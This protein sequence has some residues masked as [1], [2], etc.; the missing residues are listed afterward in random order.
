MCELG[1]ETRL[2]NMALVSAAASWDGFKGN[3]VRAV[4]ESGHPSS[5]SELCQRLEQI[6]NYERIKEPLARRH[7][8]V[9]YSARVDADY[10]RDVPSSQLNI[11]DPLGISL[12]YLKEASAS[13]FET[14]VDL[15]KVLVGEGLIPKEYQKTI[16][17]FQRDPSLGEMTLFFKK[18]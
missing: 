10:K 18:K 14:A 12:E 9:H 2:C 3:I 1:Y 6:S 13:F 7:C 8:I 16:G 4:R 5:E 11:G 17:E 15:V